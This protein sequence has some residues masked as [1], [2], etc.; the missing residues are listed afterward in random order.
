MHDLMNEAR[1]TGV[2][3]RG[4]YDCRDGDWGT[5]GWMDGMD[6]QWVSLGTVDMV[7]MVSMV[8]S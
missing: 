8:G 7:D 5:N 1:M 6:M 3:G 4:L 2:W